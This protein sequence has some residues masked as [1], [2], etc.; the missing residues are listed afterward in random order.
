MIKL[1]CLVEAEICLQDD[2]DKHLGSLPV[3]AG[4]VEVLILYEEIIKVKGT[5]TIQ[6][7]TFVYA[8]LFFAKTIFFK[9]E[10]IFH[11]VVV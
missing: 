10:P 1:E 4:R 2:L 6:A 8:F 11:Y 5:R 9:F 7:E 3:Y